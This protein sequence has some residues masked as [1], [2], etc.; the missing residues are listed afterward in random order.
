MRLRRYPHAPAALEA[1]PP[2]LSLQT[3][4]AAL[5]K[6]L[7]EAQTRES[8]LVR[9]VIGCDGRP[10]VTAYL[11]ACQDQARAGNGG[12]AALAI[13][14]GNGAR[15]IVARD[16]GRSFSA[17]SGYQ[18][19]GLAAGAFPAAK[20]PTASALALNPI[21]DI[22]AAS[23]HT[24]DH[25]AALLGATITGK[26]GDSRRLMVCL[27]G[28]GAEYTPDILAT[29][30]SAV[31][32]LTI[33]PDHVGNIGP[34]K[35]A[36]CQVNPPAFLVEIAD[37]GAKTGD[38]TLPDDDGYLQ[39]PLTAMAF[40]RDGKAAAI[41]GYNT[42]SPVAPDSYHRLYLG[43]SMDTTPVWSYAD[44][45]LR[46][47]QVYNTRCLAWDDAGNLYVAVQT[48]NGSG[49]WAIAR[50]D[51]PTS[52][53][54]TVLTPSSL[55]TTGYALA[56]SRDGQWLAY[57]YA[58]GSTLINLWRCP[59]DGS[60][61]QTLTLTSYTAAAGY[62]ALAFG[63]DGKLFSLVKSGGTAYLAVWSPQENGSQY[64]SPPEII[65]LPQAPWGNGWLSVSGDGQVCA[66][67]GTG[68]AAADIITVE[69][70]FTAAGATTGVVTAGA[71]IAYQLEFD[72]EAGYLDAEDLELEI[73][74]GPVTES[75][76]T[77]RTTT[78]VAYRNGSVSAAFG[79]RITVPLPAS[80]TVVSITGGGI[81]DTV[82]E[83][84]TWFLPSLASGAS[85]T[86]SFVV[87]SR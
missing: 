1:G 40:S 57:G 55:P 87:Q 45:G 46:N 66:I 59:A 38:T 82:A 47:L 13:D 73:T 31:A 18:G 29:A 78:T 3:A 25:G 27:A 16:L 62:G 41:G 20:S 8:G 58:S 23:I 26:V 7:R 32:D 80:R 69:A 10:I 6:L 61:Q 34:D 86:V 12:T 5:E 81:R 37:S 68:N 24:G 22:S 11:G 60:P 72:S 39:G 50:L 36:L 65:S 14:L 17:S 30:L 67:R 42:D 51:P 19:T 33:Q 21:D 85:G 63:P 74:A 76:G 52:A 49:L 15:V 70:P 83:T 54:T 79:I 84:I 53:V 9:T 35:Y 48:T 43:A 64:V 44:L 56:V 71:T 4:Q 75:G 77:L 28:A 2:D